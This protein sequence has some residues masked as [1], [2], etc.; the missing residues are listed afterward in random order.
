MAI[1]YEHKIE[2]SL[3]LNAKRTDKPFISWSEAIP[4]IDPLYVFMLGETHSF[5]ER[6]YWSDRSNETSYVGL[7]CTYAIKTDEHEERFSTVEREWK[8]FVDMTEIHSNGTEASPLLFGGF[9]FDPLKTKTERWREFASA[10]FVVPSVLLSVK[11]GQTVLTITVPTQHCEETAEQIGQLVTS[12]YSDPFAAYSSPPPPV[13]CE[14]IKK[15]EW[16]HAVQAAID[17]IGS[18]DFEKVVLAREVRFVFQDRVSPGVALQRLREQ[19]PHSYLFAFQQGGSCFV[20]ASPEQLVKKDGDAFYSLCLAGSIRRGFTI[21]EDEELG[22]WLLQ[23]EKNLSEHAFV[24]HMIR[25]AMTEVCDHVTIPSAPQLLKM[26]DIQHLYTPV[27]G[28]GRS[29]LSL[30]S[31]VERLHPT[32][33]LGGTPRAKALEAIRQLEPLDRGW[34]AAPIGWMDAKGDGEFAVAIRSGLLKG[35]QAFLFAGCGVVG[36]SEPLSEYEE[37]KVKLKPMLSA[38]G[39]KQDER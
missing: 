12:L 38:L 3:R 2:K 35:T 33:A 29:G 25:E 32:P 7:G 16:L 6:F 1:S 10:M 13:E 14:E 4:C 28:K 20:G 31:L 30:F 18:G 34:Y 15:D 9:S 11:N 39:V 19:Q 22:Q 24:V 37:T 8:R 21:Q 5:H 27:V 17:R 36:N 23:D 26:R